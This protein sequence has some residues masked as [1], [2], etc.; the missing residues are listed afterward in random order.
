[1]RRIIIILSIQ[2][3]LINKFLKMFFLHF[4]VVFSKS[5][6]WLLI[7]ALHDVHFARVNERCSSQFRK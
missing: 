3:W 5:S 7:K 1:M 2:L 4:N 6:N